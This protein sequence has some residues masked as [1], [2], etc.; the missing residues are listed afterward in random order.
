MVELLVRLAV[1][2]GSL[3][4]TLNAVD[5]LLHHVGDASLNVRARHQRRVPPC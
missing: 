1:P 5:M 3:P 4:D 2:R